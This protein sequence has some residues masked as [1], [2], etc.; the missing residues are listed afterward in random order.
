MTMR[1]YNIVGTDGSWFS[2]YGWRARAAILGKRIAVEW[3][4]VPVSQLQSATAFAGTATTPLLVDNR[5]GDPVLLKDTWSIARYLDENFPERPLFPEEQ[6][7]AIRLF[8]RQLDG[9]LQL[10]GFAAWSPHYFSN[11]VISGQDE[12]VFR[13]LV[14]RA[15]G[16]SVQENAALHP[17]LVSAFRKRL[18]PIEAQ[19][20]EYEWLLRNFSYADILLLS[21][22]KCF[23]TVLRGLDPV[24]GNEAP[25]TA[26]RKWYSRLHTLC[27][28]NDP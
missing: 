6:V 15:T 22:L 11:G 21:C 26:L 18:E 20:A 12:P 7:P 19:L 23:A 17:E 13:D 3:V 9:T 28:I 25:F 5:A 10:P 8:N 1:I 14:R 4:D 16:R 24:L 27:H 2:P